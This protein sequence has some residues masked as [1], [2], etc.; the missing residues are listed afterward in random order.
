MRRTIV[1]LGS[2]ALLSCGATWGVASAD[3]ASPPNG[4]N[5]AGVIVSQSAGPGFGHVVS[6]AAHQQL[7]DNFGLADCGQT[8]RKNP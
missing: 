4:H 1:V 7:V 8:N 5:C 3:P 2:A 6:D